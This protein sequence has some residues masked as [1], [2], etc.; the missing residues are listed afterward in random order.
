M[1]EAA[2]LRVGIDATPLLGPRT[3][4]G[5]YVEHLVAAL[6]GLEGLGELRATAF[7]WR[8]QGGLAAA[9][10]A[11]VTVAGRRAPARG[12]QALWRRADVPA[13]E[14]LAGRVDVF[15]GTNFV[16]PPLR[17]AGGVLTVHDLAYLTLPGTVSA[18]SLRYRELVPR[19]LRR[20]AVVLTPTE[21][22]AEELRTA[23]PLPAD[24]VL[25]TPLGVDRVWFETPPPDPGWLAGRGLPPEYLL[26]VGTLEPRKGL[27][28]LVAAYRQ[29]SAEEPATPPLVLVGGAGWGAG[30]DLAGL[31]AGRV[32]LPGYVDNADLVPIM[33]GARLLAFP[34]R[35]EGF[36]LPPLEAMAAGVPVVASDLP[37]VREAT[38]E[39][40][41]LVPPGDPATL[42]AELAAELAAPADPAALET[43]RKHAAG[44]TWLR[45]AQLTMRAY[46]R[47]AAP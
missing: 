36:G 14:L 34:S 21:A 44:H 31:P 13:V 7:T 32:V 9:V 11:G 15:H 8:G 37:A 39:L 22:V 35:Y 46:Q 1:R 29:L 41:R 23:Y 40:V 4:V 42:A 43:A 6:S 27:D 38:G 10:P 20:A 33:A 25:V 24:R 12:L 19:S 30:L 18:A 3:G 45:C 28:V 16:L 17:R 5:R 26:A 2:G 47:A